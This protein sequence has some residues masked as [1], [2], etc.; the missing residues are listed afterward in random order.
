MTKKS[1]TATFSEKLTKGK[2]KLTKE[3]SI[4]IFALKLWR[5]HF[6]KLLNSIMRYFF[7][8][9][10]AQICHN[11]LIDFSQFFLLFF[12]GY[13]LFF[14]TPEK[15]FS[16]L[17]NLYL[18][19]KASISILINIIDDC[20]LAILILSISRKMDKI[21]KDL[22]EK[23]IP[24]DKQKCIFSVKIF[25]FLN[26]G[27]NI[28]RLGFN[29]R[30]AI[31]TISG[32]VFIG[33]F[34]SGFLDIPDY[35]LFLDASNSLISY[36]KLYIFLFRLGDSFITGY[37]VGLSICFSGLILLISLG[38]PLKS[39]SLYKP[40]GGMTE[41]G[42]GLIESH[43][44]FLMAIVLPVFFID[45][46]G[47][48]LLEHNPNLITNI[49][50]GAKQIFIVYMLYSIVLSFIPVYKLHKKLEKTKE[51]KISEITDQLSEY[52]MKFKKDKFD[53]K[54]EE[55]VPETTNQLYDHEK[56]LK[57][58][59]LNISIE[60]YTRYLY[61]LSLHE[62]IGSADTLPIKNYS[63]IA[64]LILTVIVAVL[65]AWPVISK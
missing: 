14:F 63:V 15:I 11:S 24:K 20:I 53:I 51:E 18:Y 49:E 4:L 26:N 46:T 32:L 37:A 59:E 3:K 40:H 42:N 5:G 27:L 50:K 55:K 7:K 36:A 9:E 61:L 28:N 1:I 47:L 30:I 35:D 65:T 12:I 23:Y 2:E 52:E 62:R 58:N 16:P 10:T 22:D 6:Y 25:N 41:L 21:I 31:P 38:I 60:Y 19:K 64:N 54:K 29:T 45:I 43:L 13:L 17:N 34:Q 57:E 56:K 33:L 48:I 44:L 39:L 8:D